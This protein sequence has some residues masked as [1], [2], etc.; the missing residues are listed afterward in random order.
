MSNT[1]EAQTL[2]HDFYSR[3]GIWNGPYV[4]HNEEENEQF[5]YPDKL[6]R[7]TKILNEVRQ[8]DGKGEWVAPSAYHA[9]LF[10]QQLAH[11]S[12]KIHKTY[13]FRGHGNLSW[14]F[15]P[16][17]S[18]PGIDIAQE[19]K[20]I[21]AF[22]WLLGSYF[23]L[24]LLNR[25]APDHIHVATAQHYQLK[26]CLLDFAFDPAVT[27]YFA[28]TS[29]QE[30]D[31]VVFFES[32]DKVMDAGARVILPPPFVERLYMQ[33]GFFIEADQETRQFL[34]E[35]A[36]KIY[37]PKDPSFVCYRNAKVVDLWQ[38]DVWIRAMVKF[39]E[40]HYNEFDRYNPAGWLK[41][42]MQE[43][44]QIPVPGYLQE[45]SLHSVRWIEAFQ[46]MLYWS[47]ITY[48]DGN[49]HLNPDIV[50]FLA[51]NN[52]GIAE[53]AAKIFLASS[54]GEYAD[55]RKLLHDLLMKG[56]NDAS[57]ASICGTEEEE[58]ISVQR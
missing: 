18:R 29:G 53:F 25:R 22:C 57:K 17:L 19:K 39:T 3:A 16:T 51:K 9:A 6:P 20:K 31:S 7:L 50:V 34:Q 12:Q 13:I 42:H 30:G 10:L 32:F 14:T 56:V 35:N 41:A 4:L 47:A 28:A 46:E 24:S 23:N 52:P 26:T 45:Q 37:F 48:I 38:D 40:E 49:E 54:K 1:T 11:R 2:Y 33:T 8:V 15:T 58:N 55:G 27:V 43:L 36:M 21:E 44:I 5:N